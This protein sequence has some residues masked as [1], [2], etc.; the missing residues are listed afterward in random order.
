MRQDFVDNLIISLRHP[1]W[2]EYLFAGYEFV[3]T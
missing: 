3:L 1:Y 2:A